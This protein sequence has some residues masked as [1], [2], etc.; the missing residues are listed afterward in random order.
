MISLACI[1]RVVVLPKSVQGLH[2]H[3]RRQI[4]YIY[5]VATKYDEGL[6][7]AE[8]HLSDVTRKHVQPVT[9]FEL[10][11]SCVHC[12]GD[13]CSSVNKHPYKPTTW[14]GPGSPIMAMHQSSWNLAKL[15]TPVITLENVRRFCKKRNLACTWWSVGFCHQ[16]QDEHGLV[17]IAHALDDFEYVQNLVFLT[18]V[19]KQDPTANGFCPAATRIIEVGSSFSQKLDRNKAIDI[20]K[21]NVCDTADQAL[22]HNKVKSACKGT[23]NA[24]ELDFKLPPAAETLGKPVTKRGVATGETYGKIFEQESLFCQPSAMWSLQDCIAIRPALF[25]DH[26]DSG[27]L[28]VATSEPDTD[29]PCTLQAYGLVLGNMSICTEDGMELC[30][31]CS[32]LEA[33]LS[34]LS[35]TCKQPDSEER[36]A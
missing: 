8:Q 5:V 34:A 28:V 4:I 7:F 18:E 36:T 25:A 20:M 9:P 12:G 2:L 22:F 14:I 1:V 30:V 29:E 10:F 17:S 32:K 21:V 27:S 26:G 6:A 16:T 15:Y 31:I 33:N 19:A 11:T 35:E 3:R 13:Q 24:V 23:Y